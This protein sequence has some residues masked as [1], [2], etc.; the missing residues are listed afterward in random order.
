MSKNFLFLSLFIFA[1]VTFSLTDSTI[2]DKENNITSVDIS[3]TFRGQV[4]QYNNILCSYREGDDKKPLSGNVVLPYTKGFDDLEE[5][6][7]KELLK[8][9][10]DSIGLFIIADGYT[11]FGDIR[12]R[13]LTFDNTKTYPQLLIDGK[14]VRETP[15]Y[16][17]VKH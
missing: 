1:I 15:G 13:N 4:A 14:A 11:L 2:E 5:N 9:L 8:N 10:T 7:T 17:G 12:D 6:E 3:L 16:K